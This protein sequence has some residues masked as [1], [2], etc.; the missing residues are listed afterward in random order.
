M[1]TNV[2]YVPSRVT[3]DNRHIVNQPV[4]IG[5]V[6]SDPALVHI[7]SISVAVNTSMLF[8]TIHSDSLK[9]FIS[10]GMPNNNI[11]SRFGLVGLP[12][13]RISE[14]NVNDLIIFCCS[15]N[16]IRGV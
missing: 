14:R 13:V 6:S 9:Q 7:K 3:F 15:Y 10:F 1:H 5:W 16:G 11:N 2:S 12:M 8:R 4:L